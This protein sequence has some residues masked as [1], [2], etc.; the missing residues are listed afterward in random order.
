VPR[1]AIVLTVLA[2]AFLLVPRPGL[3]QTEPKQPVTPSP[4]VSKPT[5]Q[6]TTSARGRVTMRV[7]IG[8]KAPDFELDGLDGKPVRLSKMRGDWLALVFVERRDSLLTLQPMAKA[9]KDLGVK[10]AAVC[11]DKPQ[12]LATFL[13]GRDLGLVTLADPTG[14]IV[15]LY[16]LMNPLRDESAPGF[17]LINPIGDVRMALMGL[18]LT[19]E[20]ASRL[21]E[22]AVTGE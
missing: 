6:Q 7:V 20:D 19:N 21:V 22:F 18:E 13:K 15:A 17:V 14:E 1:F 8:E 12:A 11:Y 2:L 3:A 10:T 4:G 5:S 16:G 9:L